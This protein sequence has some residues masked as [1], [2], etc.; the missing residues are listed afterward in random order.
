M[1]ASDAKKIILEKV[2]KKEK[3]L[4]LTLHK[5]QVPAVTQILYGAHK[6]HQTREFKGGL[7]VDMGKEDCCFAEGGK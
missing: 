6:L 1:L 4:D 7:S 5:N 2:F 3:K